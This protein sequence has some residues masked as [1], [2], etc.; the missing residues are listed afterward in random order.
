MTKK[1]KV[2]IALILLIAAASTI[3]FTA[4]QKRQADRRAYESAEYGDDF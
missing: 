4:Y 1:Q 2:R 3:F